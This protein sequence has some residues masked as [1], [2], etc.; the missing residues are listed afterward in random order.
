MKILSIPL[1]ETV[2]TMRKQVLK[3]VLKNTHS[4]VDM[5]ELKEDILQKVLMFEHDV[6]RPFRRLVK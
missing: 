6:K 4:S 3:V 1:Y 5:E 2:P